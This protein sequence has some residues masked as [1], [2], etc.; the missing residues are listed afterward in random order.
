MAARGVAEMILR[1]SI[2]EDGEARLPSQDRFAG[3]EEFW[4]AARRS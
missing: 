2:E 1:T 3:D 4:P